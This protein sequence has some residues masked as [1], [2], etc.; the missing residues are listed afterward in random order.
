MKQTHQRVLE[1]KS[2]MSDN[3]VE[4]YILSFPEEIQI[5]LEQLRTIIRK[6]APDAEEVISYHMPAYK[7][8]GMLVYFAAHTN[9]IGFYPTPSGIE[10]FADDLK[11]YKTSK[12]AI[13]FPLGKPLPV[14]LIEKIVL[15]RVKENLNKLTK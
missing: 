11:A 2:Q 15:F 8:N 1:M 9:H 7:L 14:K 3:S 12:G 13:Q 4:N 5:L 6:S 10:A